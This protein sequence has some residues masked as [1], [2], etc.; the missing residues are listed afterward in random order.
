MLVKIHHFFHETEKEIYS[1][2]IDLIKKAS[3]YGESKIIIPLRNYRNG[4]SLV[5]E[6]SRRIIWELKKDGFKT[7]KKYSFS[8][9]DIC[10]DLI[11]KW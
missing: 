9:L 8:G 4:P 2:I 10:T 5:G 1:D 7:K 3:S 6:Y 11:I